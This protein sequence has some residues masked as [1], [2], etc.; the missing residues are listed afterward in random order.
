MLRYRSRCAFVNGLKRAEAVRPKRRPGFTLVELLVVIAIIGVLVALLL[1]AVQA[2]R[3]AARRAQCMNALHNLA[4]AVL[5]F[6]SAKK[7]L[8][9]S[10]DANLDATGDRVQ[11]YTGS[12]LSWIVRVLPYM[13]SSSLYDQ[14]DLKKSFTTY[15]A[16][17]ISQVPTPEAAQPALLLCPSD[18]AQGRLYGG[19]ARINYNGNRLFGKGNY[20]AYASAEHIECQLQAPGSLL[21]VPQP[22]SRISDGTSQVLMLTEVRTRDEPSDERG[23]WA[24]AWTGTSILGADVHGAGASLV[25]ICGIAAATRPSYS[26]TNIHASYALLPNAPVPALPEGAKDNL[27]NCNNPEDADLLGM[28]CRVRDDTS[29]APRS[30][31]PG[32]VN[33]A[34]VD[35]SVRW[36]NDN[37]DVVF[38]GR[39]V[40]SNDGQVLAE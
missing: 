3:E 7:A 28:P 36:V 11:L 10:S 22:L 40:C 32:G 19:G 14:F 18:N 12:Q 37:V 1:P 33:G 25:R 39:L 5:N 21:N 17:N 2:A 16:E 6:E 4:I 27:R 13:E 34:H 20:V 30:Q 9:Q 8:P 24:I 31:H 35:G 38:F 23:A 29:A 15:I 26:P